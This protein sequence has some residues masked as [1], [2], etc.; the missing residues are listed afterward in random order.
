M[1]PLGVWCVL[2][3]IQL[4]YANTHTHLHSPFF[5]RLGSNILRD[6]NPT[7]FPHPL[8]QPV[9]VYSSSVLIL[10]S[11]FI[12]GQGP[13]V[14]PTI[15]KGQL[16]PRCSAHAG[17]VQPVHLS[18]APALCFFRSALMLRLTPLCLTP[19]CFTSHH[20]SICNNK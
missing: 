15:L 18:S 19:L 6:G 9:N 1:P 12:R 10:K 13:R 2:P 3:S 4:L 17:P 5:R 7:T 20:H 8:T 14:L 16:W 11:G